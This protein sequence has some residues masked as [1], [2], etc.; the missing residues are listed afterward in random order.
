MF[1]D[2]LIFCFVFGTS[3]F[4]QLTACVTLYLTD[5]FS[6]FNCAVSAKI[7]FKFE[8]PEFL[9]TRKFWHDVLG[10]ILFSQKCER[11][12]LFHLAE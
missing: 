12:I 4:R 5:T 6:D 7:H 1:K 10:S 3:F 8:I 2:Y 9:Y 11:E